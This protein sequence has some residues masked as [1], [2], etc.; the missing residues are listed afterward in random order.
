MKR[1]H[2]IFK[3]PG[4]DYVIRVIGIQPT[5]FSDFYHALLRYSWWVTIAAISVAFLAANVVFALLFLILGGIKNAAPGSFAD[6][7]F[8]S[9]QTM[10]TI[11]YGALYPG[12]T[13][14]NLLVVAEAITGLSL[15]ALA[16]GLVFAKFS[17]P[18][19]R[20]VFSR[21]AVI[22]PLNGVPTLAFRLGN[23]RANQIVD[24]KIRVVMVRTEKTAEGAAFYRLLD[25]K[26]TRDRALSLSRSWSVLH[27][28]DRDSPLFGATPEKLL[29]EEVELQVM[30]V[31]LDDTTMATIH[32]S[33]RYFA[34]QI[35]FGASLADVLSEADDGNL[36]LDLR[37]FHE[38][39]PTQPTPDFPYPAARGEG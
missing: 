7:F 19:A 13:A 16:T 24:A 33:H 32:A 25:L 2:Q 12:S 36:V 11:G 31:G 14:S 1:E 22:F 4:A 26:L 28:L 10:G 23:Q 6:A 37:R 30:V 20:L 5:P 27:I 39:R 3:V 9:V 18:T 21:S 15:T 34:P 8:F 38:V 35:H 17:L 29:A